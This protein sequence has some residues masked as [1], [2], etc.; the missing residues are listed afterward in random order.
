MPDLAAL[1]PAVPVGWSAAS[2]PHLERFR[3]QLQTDVLLQRTY[4]GGPANQ[5]IQITLYLAYW[6]P[7]QTPVS[8]V[9]AHTPDACWPGAGWVAGPSP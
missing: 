5:R 4:L 3:D 8:L 1:M 7:G 9:D 6:R 2:T